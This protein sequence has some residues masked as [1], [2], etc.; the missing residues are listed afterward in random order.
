MRIALVDDSALA[1]EL[2]AGV[3]RDRLAVDVTPV[4]AVADYIS[5]LDQG[6]VFD[7]ALVDL[8]FPEERRTGLDALLHTH[9]TAPQTLLAIITQGDTFVAELLRD[10]WNLLPV[11]TVVSKSAP[12]EYQLAQIARVLRDGSAPVDPSV[13]PL[14]PSTPS[15]SRGLE[16]YRRLVAHAG[17]AKIWNALMS[18]R[19][20]VTYQEVV[21]HT[22]LRLNTVKNYR[23]QLLDPMQRLGLADPSLR[24]M[25]QFAIRVAPALNL[26]IDQLAERRN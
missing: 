10:C 5:L 21:V 13:E 2:F 11:T 3:L 16:P 20:E 25:R 9:R 19:D 18:S 7:L 22:G 6:E 1:N 23:A 17:H 14:L 15:G 24:E 26:I 12:I 4:A 8:S